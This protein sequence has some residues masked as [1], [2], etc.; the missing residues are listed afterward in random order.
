[1]P[2]VSVIIPAAGSGRRFGSAQNKIFQQLAGR[3]IFLR[4]IDA[5]ASRSD[6]TQIQLVVSVID[7]QIIL[8]RFSRELDAANVSLCHGGLIRTQSVANALARVRPAC[9]LV[10]IH[11]AVRPCIAPSLIDAV[12]DAAAADGAAILAVPLHGTIKRVASGL[13]SQTV[14]RHDLYEAQ[15]PQVFAR[16]LII[17]AFDAAPPDQADITDDAQLVEAIGHPVRVILGDPRN[18]KITAPADLALAEAIWP[19]IT[20]R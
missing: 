11:D 20:A 18:I 10:A 2:N 4:T 1:M 14:P 7:E 3:E 9:D 8:D 16:D 6:V 17:R 5:F 19:S 15:T 13:I 12:F